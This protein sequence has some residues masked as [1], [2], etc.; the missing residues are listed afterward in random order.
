M[1]IGAPGHLTEMVMPLVSTEAAAT[2][3]GTEIRITLAAIDCG[4]RDVD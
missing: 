1:E 2:R 3:I 4:F